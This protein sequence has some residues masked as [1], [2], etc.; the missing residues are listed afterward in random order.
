[1]TI[2]LVQAGGSTIVRRGIA[3][4]L[5]DVDDI[6]VVGEVGDAGD[7]LREAVSELEPDVLLLHVRQPD[8]APGLAQWIT[9]VSDGHNPSVLLMTLPGRRVGVWR[10]VRAG[11]D[12]YINEDDRPE[13]LVKAIRSL[14]AGEAWLPP[15]FAQE[16]VDHYRRNTVDR[17]G[18][19]PEAGVLSR[20]ERTVVRLVALGHSNAE[21]ATDLNLAEST[22]KT[23]VSRILRKLE[24]RDRTQLAHFAH[25]ANLV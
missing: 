11:V 12:G 4:I 14:A 20:R 7:R 17:M 6:D 8:S 9:E 23:H 5:H 21:I 3:D 2:R 16:L 22:V 13:D 18:T 1:M 24:L 25:Q 19:T 10:A 15:P